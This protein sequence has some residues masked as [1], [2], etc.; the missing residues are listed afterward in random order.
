MCI[1]GLYMYASLI[2][3]TTIPSRDIAKSFNQVVTDQL[4]FLCVFSFRTTCI[5]YIVGVGESSAMAQIYWR[6]DIVFIRIEKKYIT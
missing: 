6:E 5:V 4:A 2:I 1:N 3:P